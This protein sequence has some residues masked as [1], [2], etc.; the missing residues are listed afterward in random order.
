[1]DVIKGLYIVSMK[2]RETDRNT[3]TLINSMENLQRNVQETQA[4]IT[5]GLLVV[6]ILNASQNGLKRVLLHGVI[7]KR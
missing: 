2:Q 3:F 6:V 5:I 4:V 1:M 7:L